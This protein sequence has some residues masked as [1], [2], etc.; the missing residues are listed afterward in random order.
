MGIT[1][2]IDPARIRARVTIA[3]IVEAIQYLE[4]VAGCLDKKM[5]EEGLCTCTECGKEIWF[6]IGRRGGAPVQVVKHV[7][8]GA[9]YCSQACRQKAFRKRKRATDRA[10]NTAA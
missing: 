6:E 9:R 5:R 1:R 2:E 8:R 7:R 10:P 4:K 3:Q